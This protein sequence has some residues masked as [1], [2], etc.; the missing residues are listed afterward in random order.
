MARLKRGDILCIYE[1]ED[2]DFT[3]YYI[4]INALSSGLYNVVELDSEWSA[5]Q[6]VQL[7]KE[8]FTIPYKLP[9]ELQNLVS[10]E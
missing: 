8:L 7:R 6:L 10:G 9:K 2:V 5:V 1:H 3:T 4:F